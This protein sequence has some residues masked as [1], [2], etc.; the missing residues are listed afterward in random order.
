MAAVGVASCLSPAPPE[1]TS[2]ASSPADGASPEV[3]GTMPPPGDRLGEIIP[4]PGSPSSEGALYA[5]NPGAVVVYVD[6]GHG[7][8]LDWGVPNPFDN[9]LDRAEKTMTLGIALRV[10]DL[11]RQAGGQVVLSRDEDEAVAGDVDPDFGCTGPPFRDA[12]GDGEVGFDQEGVTLLRDELTARIDLA[13]L[14]RADVFIS[15]HSNSMTENDVVHEI[16]ATQTFFTDETPWGS[17]SALLAEL[18]QGE[19]VAGLG[20]VAGY[21]RQ[22][23]GVQAVNYYVI[24]PPLPTDG[25]GEHDPRA[26]PRG[27]QMPGVLAEVGSIS[28]EEESQLLATPRGQGAVADALVRAVAAYLAERER[29]VRYDALIP[30]GAGGVPPGPAPG[31]GPPFVP[32]PLPDPRGGA[33]EF[34]LRLTNTGTARWGHDP[35]LVAGWEATGEPYLVAPPDGARAL[36]VRVPALAPG[37]SV[38]VRVSVTAPAVGTRHVLWISLADGSGDYALSGSPPL[39]LTTP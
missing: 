32:P 11:V 15:V 2:G 6:A 24:A 19:V 38:R 1:G 36:D 10:G 16:A 35:V 14:S 22:D 21:E 12:N 18:V 5:P 28:L 9:T 25:G 34:D 27:I 7:G 8:C 26:R 37:E 13:N 30:G 33:F 23:R 20:E 31:D 17:A 4:A 29:S 39:Q 3:V